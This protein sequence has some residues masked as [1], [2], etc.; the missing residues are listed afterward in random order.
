MVGYNNLEIE[1]DVVEFLISCNCD[2]LIMYVEVMSDDYLWEI[3]VNWVLI[4]V[5]NW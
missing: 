4:L 1:K 2:V 3:N 5:V